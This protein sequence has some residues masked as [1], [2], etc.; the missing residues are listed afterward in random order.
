M[1]MHIHATGDVE[2]IAKAIHDA[3]ALTKTPL[4]ASASAA[5]AEVGIDTKQIDQIMAQKRKGEWRSLSIQY[6]AR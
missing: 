1:Y 6:R 3:L 4:S 2:Q 5:T